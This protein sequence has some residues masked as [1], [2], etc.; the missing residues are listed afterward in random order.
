MYK[1]E[2]A[3]NCSLQ[4][5]EPIIPKGMLKKLEVVYISW[6]NAWVIRAKGWWKQAQ[7]KAKVMPPVVQKQILEGIALTKMV[8]AE[9]MAYK[10]IQTKVNSITFRDL[11]VSLN[12]TTKNSNP[13]QLKALRKVVTA[14]TAKYSSQAWNQ[15]IIKVMV[16]TKVWNE[17]TRLQWGPHRSLREAKQKCKAMSHNEIISLLNNSTCRVLEESLT[18]DKVLKKGAIRKTISLTSILWIIL[19]ILPMS[20]SQ[21]QT[22][23]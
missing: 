3:V 9:S 18:I 7:L 8:Q 21:I 6:K 23:V 5:E 12:P 16:N 15:L 14:I 11:L 22:V 19:H 1:T 4:I 17:Q 2:V 20:H 13:L 10:I